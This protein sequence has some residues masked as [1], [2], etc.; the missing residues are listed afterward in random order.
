MASYA[1]RAY[2]RVRAIRMLDNVLEER[3]AEDVLQRIVADAPRLIDATWTPIT[4]NQSL[5][6][7]ARTVA[8]YYEQRH[9]EDVPF[10]IDH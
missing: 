3:G 8:A 7:F 5:K 9:S 1:Q 6:L 4:A 10:S 2:Q